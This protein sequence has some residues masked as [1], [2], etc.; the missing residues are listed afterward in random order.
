M[1][2]EQAVSFGAASA[3]LHFNHA[4]HLLRDPGI[5]GAR[6]PALLAGSA[7]ARELS[8]RLQAGV[9]THPDEV[10]ALEEMVATGELARDG[11][12]AGDWRG[13]SRRAL[14]RLRNRGIFPQR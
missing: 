3:L 1:L 12:A 9:Q 5:D 2:Y 6:R 10:R 8:A 7:T 4:N 13:V 11:F 14:R